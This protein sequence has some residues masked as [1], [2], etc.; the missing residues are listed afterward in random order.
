MG[1]AAMKVALIGVVA[2]R[3]SY[4]MAFAVGGVGCT[5]AVLALALIESRRPSVVVVARV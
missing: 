5:L 4:G 3:F 2:D 1:I